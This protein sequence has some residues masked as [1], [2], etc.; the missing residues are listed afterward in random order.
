MGLF[1]LVACSED[2]Y[3][4]ADKINETGV[5]DNT[6][7]QNSIKTIDPGIGYE[8]P[9]GTTERF[10]YVF[11]NETPFEFKFTAWV[12]L[13]FF[14]GNNGSAHFGQPLSTTPFFS[15]LMS[16]PTSN[17]YSI[18]FGTRMITIPPKTTETIPMSGGYILPVNPGGPKTAS[19]QYFDLQFPSMPTLTS[20]EIDFFGKRLKFVGLEGSVIDP[21]VGAVA[22]ATIRFPFGPQFSGSN[23]TLSSLWQPVPMLFPTAE[24]KFYNVVTNEICTKYQ[25]GGAIAGRLSSHP[26]THNGVL[27]TVSLYTTKDKVVVLLQ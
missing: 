7:P 18:H 13:C 8:S 19:G 5:V 25:A 16:P 9:Y 12:Q 6:G 27:Y 23:S 22:G 4:E 15:V 24:P 21:G 14:D 3:Q 11:Q 26:F 10:D 2:S 1:T 17:E 20:S